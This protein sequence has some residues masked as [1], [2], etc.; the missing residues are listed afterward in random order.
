MRDAAFDRCP[1]RTGTPWRS[2]MRMIRC[3]RRGQVVGPA[4]QRG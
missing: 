2:K 3:V 1:C 4:R